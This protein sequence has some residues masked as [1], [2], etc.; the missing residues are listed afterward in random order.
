MACTT[1]L[2]GKKASYDGS[3]LVARNEDCGPEWFIIKKFVVI[4]SNEQ[5]QKYKS[6]I[7]HVT[8]ELPSNPM[9]ITAIPNVVPKNGIWA[10]CGVNEVNVAMSATETINS[11]ARV[12]GADPMVEYHPAT[13]CSLEKEG[14]IGEEDIV[15]IVLPYIH[16]AREGVERLGA[17]LEKY[18]TYEK[19]GIAFQDKNEIWW[20]D[21]IGGHH[22]I[23]RRVPDDAYMIIANQFGTDTFD[24][25]DAMTEKK[26]YMCSKNMKEF[27]MQNHLCI[28]ISSTF[29][30]REVFGSHEDFDNV[31]NAPRVW[32]V[33]RILNPH[34]K[35]WDGPAAD[36]T[37]TAKN[38]PCSMVPE[39][40]ITIEDIKYILSSH[41]QGTPFDPYNSYGNLNMQN[42]YRVIGVSRTT[43]MAITQIRPYLPEEY[44]SIEWVCFASNIFNAMVPVYTNVEISPIYLSCTTPNISLD[45]LYWNSRILAA[46]ADASYKRSINHIRRYQN[47]VQSKSNQLINNY[48][49]KQKEE[50]NANKRKRLRE[51]G[52]KSISY[53]VSKETENVL[54]KVL[55]ELTAQM[56]NVFLRFGK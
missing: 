8:I 36:Y 55:F 17:L 54:E 56:K 46:M 39:K 21:T 51:E 43:S 20:M 27:I 14:G 22:W 33:L 5:P 44:C 47:C 18:G 52:N 29:N 16:S 7:S 11:N 34:T 50:N 26:N 4:S 38:L 45:N 6:T 28:N 32:S 15:Y 23:A 19:N 30:P 9:R 40:K 48:D 24:L 41:F 3:T 10:A 31:F 1:L 25:Q 35:K 53:M 37:P 2:V 42:N 12:L 49:I 13:E